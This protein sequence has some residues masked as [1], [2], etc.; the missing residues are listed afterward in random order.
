MIVER[1]ILLVRRQR[2]RGLPEPLD[3]PSHLT[4]WCLRYK[5]IKERQSGKK[6]REL[7]RLN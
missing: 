4:T 5:E 3:R 7:E 1:T 2:P 6:E